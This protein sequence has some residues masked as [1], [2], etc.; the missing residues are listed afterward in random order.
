MSRVKL[1]EKLLENKEFQET[2]LNCFRCSNILSIFKENG[3]E[4]LSKNISAVLMFIGSI[5]LS[6]FVFNML[7]HNSAL[8]KFTNKNLGLGILADEKG[9]PTMRGRVVHSLLF[10]LVYALLVCLGIYYLVSSAK[11]IKL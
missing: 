1:P 5:V 2:L 6:I 8:Y 7:F 9:N 4:L 10:G 11:P 3:K